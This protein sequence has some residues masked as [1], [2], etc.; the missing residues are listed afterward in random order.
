MIIDKGNDVCIVPR[1]R[2]N[3]ELRSS[4]MLSPGGASSL[5][6]EYFYGVGKFYEVYLSGELVGGIDT[7]SNF[8]NE[9]YHRNILIMNSLPYY[10]CH[11]I[12]HG[13]ACIEEFRNNVLIIGEYVM[14]TGKYNKGTYYR[15]FYRYGSAG[16]IGDIHTM[17]D[18]SKPSQIIIE[19][20][21]YYVKNY[22]FPSLIEDFMYLRDSHDWSKVT[23]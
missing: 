2:L 4:T 7:C 15:V 21:V 22:D 13:V 14:L 8:G 23:L 6:T 9:N 5:A 19:S 12:E 1:G 20:E 16:C 3:Y 10:S 11:S 17:D 18:E